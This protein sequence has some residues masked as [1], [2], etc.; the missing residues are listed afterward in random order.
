MIRQKHL[1]TLLNRNNDKEKNNIVEHYQIRTIKKTKQHIT[2]SN[3]NNK[4]GNHMPE[5]FSFVCF[6]EIRI[7]IRR[8]RAKKKSNRSNQLRNP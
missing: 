2:L 7:I 1:I 6:F 4:C 3:R 5:S 8:E